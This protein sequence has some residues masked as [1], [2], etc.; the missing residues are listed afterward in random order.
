MLHSD[1][2]VHFESIVRELD[3]HGI[4]QD[5]ILIGSW[6]LRV[7]Q[8]Y[9][10]QDPG[11]PIL[12]TK[13]LDFLVPNPPKISNKVDIPALLEKYDLLAVHDPLG[14]FS[15]YAG[16]DFE[17]EFLYSEKGR[18]EKTGKFIKEF[19]ITATPL[20]YLLFIQ[21]YSIPMIYKDFTV[22][23]PIPEV[24]VLMKYL[25]SRERSNREKIE[26]DL[27]TAAA[28]ETFL[29]RKKGE[30]DFITYFNLMPKKWRRKLM[31]ILE[32]NRSD[33]VPLLK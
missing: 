29:L 19:G 25:L 10:E 8:E 13:D 3:Q 27:K 33:L 17:V 20:R 1:D 7:Y 11:I 6:V 14:Q 26:K 23:V 15:K 24:F 2:I 16:P 4:L 22:V 12:T 9:F 18:G 21:S 28:L 5:F 30:S 32:T 31:S